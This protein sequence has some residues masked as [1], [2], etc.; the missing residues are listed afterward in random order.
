M[1]PQ[2]HFLLERIGA[3]D[4]PEELDERAQAVTE[5]LRAALGAMGGIGSGH[6]AGLSRRFVRGETVSAFL[7]LVRF[8][9][10]T[11]R[12]RP[13]EFWAALVTAGELLDP[14]DGDGRGTVAEALDTCRAR[15]AQCA[16]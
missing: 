1:L 6:G 5:H 15:L 2:D 3:F 11:G 9:P 7:T 8:G 4:V 14:A 12:G 10:R 13:Q 16:R